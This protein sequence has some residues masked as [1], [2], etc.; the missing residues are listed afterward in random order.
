MIQVLTNFV[1]VVVHDNLET[2]NQLN[3][4]SR[5][6]SVYNRFHIGPFL[7]RNASNPALRSY[8]IRVQLVFAWN[9]AVL[10][11]HELRSSVHFAVYIHE[12]NDDPIHVLLVVYADS[13]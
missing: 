10:H 4:G 8:H 5:I 3:A 2:D 11:R 12:N 6:P 1:A 13:D 9:N 7:D